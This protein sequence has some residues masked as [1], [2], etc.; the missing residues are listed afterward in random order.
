MA[1][2]ARLDYSVIMSREPAKAAVADLPF[3]QAM[4]ELEQ[5]VGELEKGQVSLDDSVALY[6]RGRALQDRCEKLLALAEA[7]VEKITLDE[8]GALKGLTPLDPPE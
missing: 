3:E 6:A 5:I 2:R 8:N 7:R 4:Q 1:I